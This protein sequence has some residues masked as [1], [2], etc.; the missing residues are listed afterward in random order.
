MQSF[1]PLISH[2]VNIIIER[3]K[4]KFENYERLGRWKWRK[5]GEKGEGDRFWN[6]YLR[7]EHRVF[8]PKTPRFQ[9]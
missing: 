3:Y 6:L 1:R 7:P 8:R 5:A 9:V 2:G 4:K